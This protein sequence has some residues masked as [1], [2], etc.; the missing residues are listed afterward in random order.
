MIVGYYKEDKE[1][2]TDHGQVI[3]IDDEGFHFECKTTPYGFV[4][5]DAKVWFQTFTE[6]DEEGNEV[7]RE[8]L[9]TQGYLWTKAFPQTEAIFKEG[10][11]QSMELDNESVQGT[12]VKS[13]NHDYEVLIIN[14]AIFSKLCIL[15]KDVE[16]C[17]EGASLTKTDISTNFSLDENF[18]NSVY[19]MMSDLKEIITGGKQEME[20]ENKVLESSSEAEVQTAYAKNDEEEKK[21]NNEDSKSEDNTEKE[22]TTEK[23]DSAATAD[24]K[25]DDDKKKKESDDKYSLSLEAANTVSIDEYNA[26]KDKYSALEKTVFELQS[27]K[28]NIEKEKKQNLINEFTML[29]DEDKADVVTNIDKYSLEDIES[30]LSVICFRKKVNFVQPEVDEIEENIETKNEE[31]ITTYSLGGVTAPSAPDWI[32]A[33][34]ATIKN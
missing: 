8:Y 26:L 31:P 11:P 17:F 13:I 32:R 18:K 1:D 12:W 24:E 27:F 21:T 20:N 22:T 16:P 2:F 3:T 30:K 15:G 28:A 7:E 29:T 14:D 34:E 19:T 33:V 25:E 9:M 23:K 10:R 6:F 5:P 4:S